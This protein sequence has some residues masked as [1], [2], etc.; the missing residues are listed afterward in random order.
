MAS[1]TLKW[2]KMFRQV[3]LWHKILSMIGISSRGGVTRH[4]LSHLPLHLTP[5]TSHITP[6]FR[7][8]AIARL[9]FLFFFARRFLRAPPSSISSLV[10]PPLLPPHPPSL[11][12]SHLTSVCSRRTGEPLNSQS[13]TKACSLG[14]IMWLSHSVLV[15]RSGNVRVTVYLS[16]SH[17]SGNY[18]A[19]LSLTGQ[20]PKALMGLLFHSEE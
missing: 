16:G 18:L 17:H 8:P 14:H 6:L 4:R 3:E 12:S 9:L 11:H 7:P 10:S 20:L 1:R 5:L 2:V 15:N 13:D 19:F